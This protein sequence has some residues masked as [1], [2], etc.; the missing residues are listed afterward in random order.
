[1]RQT[2][3]KKVTVSGDR[4]TF[5]TNFRKFEYGKE[6]F[7][8]L[9]VRRIPSL[10]DEIAIELSGERVF[11]IPEIADGFFEL[12][13]IFDFENVFGSLW[14]RDAEDGRDL[15]LEMNTPPKR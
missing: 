15:R 11:L 10:F 4:I 3:I 13:R 12:T 1:M 6:D 7:Y 9:T 5:K 8:A 2:V 14:Y